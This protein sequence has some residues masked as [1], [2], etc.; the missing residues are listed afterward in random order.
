MFIDR[1]ERLGADGQQHLLARLQPD[2]RLS[3]A[4]GGSLRVIGGAEAEL[5]ESVARGEFSAELYYRI[6]VLPVRLVPLR[7]RTHD[8]PD[9]VRLVAAHLAQ[10]LGLPPVSFT[11]SA[12]QRL[13]NYLWFGDVIELEAVLAR[14]LMLARKQPIDAGDLVFEG[15]RPLP[16]TTRAATTESTPPA[17][18]HAPADH[19]LELVVN[20][21]AHE[22]KNP[23]V[24][25][26]TF[27]Q[28]LRRLVYNGEEE[29]QVARLTGEA[30]DQIDQVI[31]NLLQFTRFETPV[32]ESVALPA[33]L[34]PAVAALAQTLK[35]RSRRVDYRPPPPVS[36]WVDRAQM[37]YA[38]TNLFRG[39]ARGLGETGRITVGVRDPASIQIELPSGFDPTDSRLA[40][41]LSG[42]VDGQAPLPL[43]TAIAN[44]LIE[45]NG[46]VLAFELDRPPPTV[47]VHL[48]VADQE[49][50][51]LAGNGK[52]SRPHRR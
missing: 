50:S 18:A 10:S 37:T 47:T 17:L 48:P 29:E 1:L 20:E 30:V 44:S 51:T 32:R 11:P 27:A 25:I 28:H 22:L 45:R 14:T 36:V 8:I 9:L 26:K 43:T 41:Y 33:L 6:S 2:G 35:P 40:A 42:G 12:L 23:M 15:T 16:P 7:E 19:T 21:L 46:G 38:L 13:S 4:G 5:E 24:T 3:A 31:E 52:A 49:E 39:L 34:G